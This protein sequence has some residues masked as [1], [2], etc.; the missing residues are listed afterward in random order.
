MHITLVT[1]GSRGDIQPFAALGVALKQAGHSVRA[2]FPENFAALAQAQNLDF[3]PLH[4]DWQALLQG[5][6]GQRLMS[7]GT[8]IVSATRGFRKLLAPILEGFTQDIWEAAQGADLIISHNLV[9]LFAHIPAQ[10]LSIPLMSVEPLPFNPT[11]AI[12]TPLFPLPNLGGAL[13]LTTSLM[14]RRLLWL[15][16]GGEVNRLRRKYGLASCSGGAYFRY[17]DSCA[18]L[19]AYSTH[20]FPRPA[21]WDER[22]HLTGYWYLDEP[23]WTPPQ[24]LLDFLQAGS[25]PIYVGFGS[26]TGGDPEAASRSIFDSIERNNV[27]AVV[28]GGWGGIQQA[29]VPNVY[30]LDSAPHSWLFPCMSAIVHHGGAGT[31]AAGLRAGVPSVIVPHIADQFFWGKRLA[32]LGVAAQPIPRKKLTADKL[33]AGIHAALDP[34]MRARAAELGAKIRA[35]DGV[36]NAVRLIEQYYRQRMTQ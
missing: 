35:E 22:L 36:G 13:N 29:D 6:S 3:F 33:A 12:P 31:T 26:M 9:C 24:A 32:G 21:D 4:G 19:E 2:A 25:P 5:T 34:A 10:K 23:N 17:V 15:F 20:V 16:F 18:S 27:R 8:N 7:G 11:R 14:L 1:A 30:F 28:S